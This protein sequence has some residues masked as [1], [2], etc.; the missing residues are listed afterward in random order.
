MLEVT[1]L[2]LAAVA[3][4]VTA[5]IVSRKW[6]LWSEID[7]L[8]GAVAIPLLGNTYSLL[9]MAREDAVAHVD[10]ITRKYWPIHRSWLGPIPEVHISK[11]EH[12]EKIMTSSELITKADSYSFLHPWLGDGLLTS[13]GPKWHSH[14]KMITPAFHFSILDNFVE[15]FAEKSEVLVNLLKTKADGQ[16]FDMYPYITRCAL[17]IICETAMGTSIDAQHNTESDYVAAVY[18]IA[19]LTIRRV[20]SP[21]LLNDFMF[22]MSPSGK[23]F[24]KQLDVLHGFTRKVIQ[25]KKQSRR[26]SKTDEK[27]AQYDVLGRKRRVALLDMLLVESED[28]KK[29]TDTELQEEVDTFMFEGHD[30]TT[31]GMSWVLILLGHHPGIQERV[32]S[33]QKDIFQ[34]DPERS[35]TMQDLHNM[36]YLEMVIKE[37]L[38]LYPSVPFIGRKATQDIQI[39]GYNIPEGTTLTLHIYHAHRDP[40]HWPDPERFDPDNF[41]PERVQG[42]HPFAYVPF[43]GGP[44]NCIGQKFAIFEEKTVLSYILRNFRVETVEKLEDLKLIGE[45]VLRPF[46]GVF[47]RLTPR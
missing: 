13:T 46:K 4:A 28:G 1:A 7:K 10:K 14:R 34:D 5:S 47:L 32:Y 39:A 22:R 6:R 45:L 44:R 23:K 25:Q 3:V 15:V 21:W 40:D 37:S 9:F 29:L 18:N 38:R 36:K 24:Y 8:P 12:L 31:V 2:L 19:E 11:P 27:V 20:V 33:E 26:A 16:S 41:L 35:P 30:T 42:R 43:S 17:D